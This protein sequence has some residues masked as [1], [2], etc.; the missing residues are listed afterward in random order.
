[1]QEDCT[2]E[3]YRSLLQKSPIQESILR[4]LL[5]VATPY[6]RDLYKKTAKETKPL[7]KYAFP[8]ICKEDNVSKETMH[9][10][11]RPIKETYKR[12]I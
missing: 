11:K 10:Q 6:Q 7:A 1:L 9:V 2:R 5:L 3:N 8:R 4:S 12:D